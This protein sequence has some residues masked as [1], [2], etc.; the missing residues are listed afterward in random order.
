MATFYPSAADDLDSTSDVDE[1]NS[2]SKLEKSGIKLRVSRNQSQKQQVAAMD[3]SPELGVLT[4]P[5]ASE[6]APSKGLPL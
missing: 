4:T 6:S 1:F 5:D 2:A 3:S